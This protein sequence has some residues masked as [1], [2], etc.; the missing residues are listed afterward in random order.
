MTEPFLKWAQG[1]AGEYGG[2]VRAVSGDKL[3]LESA[4]VRWEQLAG[5]N[6]PILLGENPATPDEWRMRLQ[7]VEKRIAQAIVSAP[8]SFSCSVKEAGKNRDANLAVVR[9]AFGLS[10]SLGVACTH[11]YT[12]YHVNGIDRALY[13]PGQDR[14]FEICT[15]TGHVDLLDKHL[16]SGL[17]QILNVIPE[18]ERE[19]EGLESVRQQLNLLNNNLSAELRDL[20]RLY[21]AS[22]GQYAQL[23]GKPSESVRGDDAIELEYFNKLEDIVGRYKMSVRFVPLNLGLVRC[24]VKTKKTKGVVQISIPFVDRPFDL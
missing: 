24:K 11:R 19:Y 21:I 4:S 6:E 9:F 12:A 17:R 14:L 20:D 15:G 1:L 2:Q 16:S 22:Q 18:V 7:H 3:L 5:G 13:I 8:L 10:L 23:L